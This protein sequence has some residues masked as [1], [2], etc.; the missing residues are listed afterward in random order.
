MMYG[1]GKWS[2]KTKSQQQQKEIRISG[3]ISRKSCGSL[4]NF[5][6]TKFMDIIEETLN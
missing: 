5:N 1:V 2:N 6:S 4:I 3:H